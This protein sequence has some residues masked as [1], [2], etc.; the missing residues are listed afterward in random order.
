[1]RNVGP[2]HGGTIFKI[3]PGT[4]HGT[5]QRKKL[6][7]LSSLRRSLNSQPHRAKAMEFERGQRK[8]SF[9]HLIRS[10]TKIIELDHVEFPLSVSS[11]DAVRR[12]FLEIDSNSYVFKK[13]ECFKKL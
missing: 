4:L 13:N 6:S 7:D 9:F 10:F 8:N 11:E 2:G 3:S 12:E 1:M 5:N